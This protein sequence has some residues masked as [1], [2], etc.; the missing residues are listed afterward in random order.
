MKQSTTRSLP[1]KKASRCLSGCCSMLMNGLVVQKAGPD[2]T[3]GPCNQLTIC[4]AGRKLPIAPSEI[5]APG[6]F[7][8]QD[9]AR[10]RTNWLG[11]ILGF[12]HVRRAF[13]EIPGFR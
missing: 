4:W 13:D 10:S 8:R 6:L 7:E 11:C 12:P 2:A 1:A 9:S 3:I 5:S